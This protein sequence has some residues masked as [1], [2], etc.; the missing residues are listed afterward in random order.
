MEELVL[1]VLGSGDGVGEGRGGDGDVWYRAKGCCTTCYSYVH[2][3]KPV[4]K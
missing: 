3:L 4:L 2:V 1:L